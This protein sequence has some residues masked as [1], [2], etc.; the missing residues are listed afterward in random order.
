MKNK[1]DSFWHQ[2]SARDRK[3][4]IFGFVATTVIISIKFAILPAFDWRS[5]LTSKLKY[6]QTRLEKMHK[7]VS[8]RPK[9]DAELNKIEQTTKK[10]EQRLIQ[11]KDA[12]LASAEI[13]KT[14]RSLANQA[15]IQT[16]RISTG[17]PRDKESNFQEITVSIP[18]MRCSMKQ[19]A[20][21]LVNIKQ[22]PTLLTINELRIRVSNIKDPR[23]VSVNL[24]ISGYMLKP[25]TEQQT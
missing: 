24:E 5:D 25:Q 8:N 17:K 9:L 12:D 21:F 22:S 1:F 18:S 10:F 6:E 2:L 7:I 20:E 15:D 16:S 3:I 19:L 13:I 4:V 11:A 23:E 14:V